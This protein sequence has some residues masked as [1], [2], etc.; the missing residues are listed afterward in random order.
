MEHSSINVTMD[1][2]GHL[3]KAV[4]QD[5]E[6][7]IERLFLAKMGTFWRQKWEATNKIKT[8]TPP[9]GLISQGFSDFTI[10]NSL[11]IGLSENHIYVI[12]SIPIFSLVG[13]G[14]IELPTNGLK[15]RCST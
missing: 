6:K 9:H 8:V 11:S 13:R 1:I 14:R 5:A 3:M 12:L 2:Y 4:K 15:V 10:K 7:R